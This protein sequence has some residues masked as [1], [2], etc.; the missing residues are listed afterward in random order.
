MS[1][2]QNNDTFAGSYVVRF[3]IKEGSCAETYRISDIKDQPF[4]LKIFDL[5]RI[6]EVRLTKSGLPFE[7]EVCARLEHPSLVACRRT[8][9]ES[10]GNKRY[11]YLIT[12]YIQG[13]LLAELLSRE[14]RLPVEQAVRITISVLEGLKYLHNQEEPLIHNDI[15]ARNV[16]YD[17]VENAPI[18]PRI[19]DM[20]HISHP[21]MGR[22]DFQ[23]SDL[24]LCYRAPETFLGIYTR[25]SDIFSVGVLLYEM[26]FG[27]APWSCDPS[28]PASEARQELREAR[29]GYLA[30]PSEEPEGMTEQLRNVLR[31]ALA[32]SDRDRFGR[33][34]EFI[35]ALQGEEIKLP[36]P[37]RESAETRSANDDLT[38][39]ERRE[40]ENEGGG[41]SPR[42]T[43]VKGEGNGF[44]DVA[45]MEEL[46]QLLRIKVIN[47]LQDREKALKYR[48]AIP[49]GMLLYGPPGCGKTFIAEKFAEETGFNYTV[50]KSS[51][52]ASIY[53][54]GSQQMIGKLFDEA[55]A[56]APTVLCFD[57]FDALVP[58]RKDSLHSGQSGEVNEF[59]TQLN[60]CGKKG[61]FVIATSNRPDMIDP[62]VLRTGRIDRLIYVPVPDL[63]ARKALFEIDLKDRPT[64]DVDCAALAERT[65]NFVAS[66]IAYAVNDAAI[67]AAFAN[68]PITQKILCETLDCIRPS[69][70]ADMLSEYE[71]LRD[72]MTGLERL[73][74]RTPIGY[75]RQTH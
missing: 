27:G 36:P 49:N 20:G 43:F 54:H 59:L 67:T 56:K 4:F 34:E 55:R 50:V 29:K 75:K 32:Q 70:S 13:G 24:E 31:I 14:H 65:V 61:V 33:I 64:E 16:M 60:N 47:V 15:T 30:F 1:I 66:D 21:V 26:L 6:P 53:V 58:S 10:I 39:G 48:L 3:F 73:A 51:D 38:G 11:A 2:L 23:T 18:R 62:A 17:C 41:E 40:G 25:M 28:K 45:G 63:A 9:I 42:A 74:A 8:G 71:K 68:V 7:V 12:D 69:V 72:K 57:E 22:P 46:K 52:L 19:I 35:G 37:R 5:E 44:D